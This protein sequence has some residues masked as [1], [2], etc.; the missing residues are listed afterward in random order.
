M[1]TMW[2]QA[3]VLFLISS[4]AAAVLGA[5]CVDDTSRLVEPAGASASQNCGA[6]SVLGPN[7]PSDPASLQAERCFL[8]AYAACQP[9]TLTLASHGLDVTSTTTFTIQS[10]SPCG[11]AGTTETVFVPGRRHTSSFTCARITERDGG[12][13]FV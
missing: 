7:P 9:S 5:G 12:L 11:V 6:V 4:F 8:A 1:P 10:G 3:S 13:L 2:Q